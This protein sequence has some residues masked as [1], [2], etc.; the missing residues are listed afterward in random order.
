MRYEIPADRVAVGYFGGADQRKGVGKVLQ[1]G[2]DSRYVVLGAGPRS[3]TLRFGNRR[4]LGY[5]DMREVLAA[6]DVVVA[7][8]IFD[9]APVAVL[10][11]VAAGLPVVT[12]GDSGWAAPLCRFG[13]GAVCDGM[14]PLAAIIPGV[15][16]ASSSAARAFTEHYSYDA[17]KHRLADLWESQ[18]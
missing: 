17:L 9:A 14:T 18:A 2:S 1:L 8:T 11:A 5:V 4:G 12:G 6:C 3:E 15:L 7:P 10:Q 13:A 16:P